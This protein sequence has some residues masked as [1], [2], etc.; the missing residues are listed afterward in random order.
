MRE[1]KDMGQFMSCY[2][3]SEW[4]RHAGQK[5]PGK[6]LGWSTL[7][8]YN[9]QIVILRQRALFGIFPVDFRHIFE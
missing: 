2:F 9:V 7:Q 6:R 1:A 5:I 4:L 8:E 3:I